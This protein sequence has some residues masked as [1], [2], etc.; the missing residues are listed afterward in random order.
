MVARV[1]VREQMQGSMRL[2]RQS[3]GRARCNPIAPEKPRNRGPTTPAGLLVS[4]GFLFSSS[5][6]TGQSSRTGISGMFIYNSDCI[7]GCSSIGRVLGCHSGCCRFKPCRP[8][9]STA[10][11]LYASLRADT[12]VCRGMEMRKHNMKGASPSGKAP[13][14]ESAKR[15]FDSFRLRQSHQSTASTINAPFV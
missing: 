8:H 4:R 6:V 14:F 9:H 3:A 11:A 1:F 15:R 2:I 10:H 5:V 13:D 7:C 12:R